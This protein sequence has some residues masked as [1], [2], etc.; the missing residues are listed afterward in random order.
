MCAEWDHGAERCE[1]QGVGSVLIGKALVHASEPK[2][3]IHLTRSGGRLGG[4]EE[5][6]AERR[7]WV[8]ICGIRAEDEAHDA[9]DAGADM[10]GLILVST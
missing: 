4:G 9:I 6:D 5:K 10:I 2:V 8:K 3:F 7:T 1:D